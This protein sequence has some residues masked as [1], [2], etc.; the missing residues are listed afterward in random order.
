MK[1]PKTTATQTKPAP[2]AGAD[3]T[4]KAPTRQNFDYVPVIK[5]DF[6]PRAGLLS[7]Q[8]E[9]EERVDDVA[10]KKGEH[11]VYEV[12]VRMKPRVYQ[13][14]LACTLRRNQATQ[15]PDWNEQDQ[16]ESWVKLM[17][18]EDLQRAVH[19]A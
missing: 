4:K 12:A 5:V 6:E 13:A 19:S 8:R 7:Y 1:T 17:L 3:L 2:A 15:T 14:L 9:L 16:L 11:T 10:E 18:E